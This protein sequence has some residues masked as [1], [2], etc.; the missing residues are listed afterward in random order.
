MP[1]TVQFECASDQVDYRN[2]HNVSY[3][4]FFTIHCYPRIVQSCQVETNAF[5]KIGV[6]RKVAMLKPTQTLE[7]T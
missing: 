7:Q 4:T 5:E 1:V 2:K 3:F 6:C